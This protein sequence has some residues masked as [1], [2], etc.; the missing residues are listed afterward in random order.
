GA[1]FVIDAIA[2]G[3]QGM[4]SINRFVH[5][6]Q[7]LTIGRDLRTF[8]ELDRDD[9]KIEGYDDCPRQAPGMKP[10]NPIKSF[11]DF[12]L[13][14]TEEQVKKEAS[15]CL[16]CGACHVDV[17]KCIG[18]GLCTTRCNFDAIH[19]TRDIPEAATMHHAEDM[20]K[21]AFP[22]ILKRKKA[23][24]ARKKREKKEAKEKAKAKK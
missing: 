17:N 14:L 20:L 6:G 7:S 1:R 11:E 8:I 23:I 16:S 18:C 19:I 12:R 10:G 15:R 21:V 5:E 9:I 3:K 22:Y 13:P 4:V 24:K 2:E